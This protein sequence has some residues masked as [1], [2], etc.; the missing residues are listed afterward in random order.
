MKPF[1]VAR[2][3]IVVAGMLLL[4]GTTHAMKKTPDADGLVFRPYVERVP[5]QLRQ[6]TRDLLDTGDVFRFARGVRHAVL[7]MFDRK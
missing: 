3:C 5:I 1:S 2:C 6:A 7:P 4:A